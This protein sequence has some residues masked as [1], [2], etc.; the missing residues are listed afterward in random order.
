MT[1]VPSAVAASLARPRAARIAVATIFLVNGAAIANWVA[2]IPDMKQQLA[3]SDGAL[4]FALVWAAVGALIGQP[5]AG[6]LIGRLGSRRVTTLCAIGFSLVA[7]LP[8]VAPSL[9]ALMAALLI[10][11]ALNGSLDVAMNAQAAI[12]ERQ[13]ARPIMSSFHGLWSVGGLVGATIGG[14]LAA[15][16]VAVSAHLL[17]VSGCTLAV[18]L[19]A[20]RWLVPDGPAPRAE[21]PAFALP[22]RALL[23]LGVIAFAV[24]FCEGAIADWGAVYMRDT[25]RSTPDLAATGFA[26]FSLLMAAGRLSGDWLTLRVGP[27]RLVAGGGLLVTAGIA[28]ALLGGSP[29][30][31][32]IGFGLVGAGVA[33]SFPLVLSAA[34]TTPGVAPS[35]AIA[36][37]ATSGY[38][39]FLVGP[40]LIGSIATVL[41]LRGA[42][43]TLAL[44]GVLMAVLG[45]T[46]LRSRAE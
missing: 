3:L 34:A 7:G 36:A 28:L 33:C 27:S 40:P 13:Y 24:L 31:A 2:R 21:G 41:S 32:I 29:L 5:M 17:A 8:G 42:L 11:G 9:P 14:V 18:M 20:T 16:G 6:W 44:F 39:G 23:P 4:G 10:Y 43:A 12:V 19:L 45:T 1:T 26:V 35:A 15:R 46:S 37:I 30:L 38:S 25:L 22:P